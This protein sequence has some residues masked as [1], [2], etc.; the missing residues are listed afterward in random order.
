[1]V[2]DDVGIQQLVVGG[3]AAD[4]LL[5]VLGHRD[6]SAKRVAPLT[7]GLLVLLGHRDISANSV[8]L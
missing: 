8:A 2:L 4:G 7:D 5:V 6:I 1:M 3:P